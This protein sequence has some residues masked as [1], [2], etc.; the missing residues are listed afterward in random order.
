MSETSGVIPPLDEAEPVTASAGARLA[1]G[2][3]LAR[4]VG[5]NALGWVLPMLLALGAIPLLVRDLGEARYGVLSLAWTL[6]GYFSL[7]D[8]GLGRALTQLVS[9]ALGS[10]RTA[11]LP[12]LVWTALWLLLPLGL[13]GGAVIAAAAPALVGHVL[14]V[15]PELQGETITAFRLL[16]VA[17]PFAVATAGLRG[18]LEAQQAFGA[19]TALRAPLA[20]A[21]FGA[22]L[23]V[24]PFAPTLPATVG[25]LTLGRAVVWALHAWVCARRFPPLRRPMRPHARH[26]RELLSIGGWMTVSNIVSPLMSSLDRFVVGAVLSMTAVAYYATAYEAV[27]R[28][29][30]VTSVLLPVLFPA[31][32][33]VVERDPRHAGELVDRGM[34]ACLLVAFPLAFLLGVFAPEWLRVWVGPQFA[35]H[36][37]TL[38]RGLAAAVLVNVAGQVAYTLIQAAGRA[39]ITGKLHLAELLPYAGALWWLLHALDTLGVV[40]AWGGRVAVDTAVLLVYAGLVLPEARRAARRGALLVGAGAPLVLASAAMPSLGARVVYAVVVLGT[41][42]VVGW[43]RML[44]PA[45]REQLLGLVRVGRRPAVA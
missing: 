38:A 16:G 36:A 1:S 21:T 33:L 22:P 32:A 18:V 5:L 40:V 9:R 23:L 4:N 42:A 43:T 27:T 15:A 14:H 2:R 25:V 3:L 29:W 10:G 39:D 41:F 19:V 6:V 13:V 11:E 30:T 34:R 45:E 8:L 12:T 26:V 17:I 44:Q 35:L 31:I 20:I 7:F 24:I 37:A 28:L